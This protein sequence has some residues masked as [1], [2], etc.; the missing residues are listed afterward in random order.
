MRGRSCPAPDRR[1]AGPLL[2]PGPH[3]R[4]RPGRAAQAARLARAADR[5]RRPGLAGRAVL[6]AAGI[7]TLGIVDDDVVDESNL[8]RQVLHTADRVGMPKTESAELTLKALNPDVTIAASVRLDASNVDELVASYDVIVDGT[9]N[10]ET[11]YLLNDASV[12]HRKPVV[13]GSIYRWDGRSRPSSRSTAR[14]TAACTPPSRR[15]SSRPRVRWPGARRAAGESSVCSRPTKRSSSCSAWGDAGRT[16]APV[17]RHEHL[18]RR[19]PPVARPRLSG[20]RRRRR[21]EEADQTPA[22]LAAS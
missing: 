3:P 12:A 10:F 7:G 19:D 8:Q 1:R 20:L 2:A 5:G 15:R 11:R 13:H 22:A 6:A 21:D 17:R 18:V 4:D 9:D 14:A 16:D